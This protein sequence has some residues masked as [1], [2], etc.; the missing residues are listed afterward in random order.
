MYRYFTYSKIYRYVD[1]LQVLVHSYNHTYHSSIGMAPAFIN[2]K[3]RGSSSS[4]IISQTPGKSTWRFVIGQR[5]TI[6]KRKQAFE[7]GYLP[8]SLEEIFIISKKCPTTPASHAIKDEADEE[9]KGRFYEPE[10]KLII[11]EDNVYDAEKV[12]KQEGET[13]KWN[14]M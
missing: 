12:I 9:I 8:G 5:V 6:S 4:K 14:I 3:K 13:A 1:V 10:R 7:K 2:V 11:K